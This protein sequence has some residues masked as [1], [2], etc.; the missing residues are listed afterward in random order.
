MMTV[1]G[2][3]PSGA[4]GRGDRS[5][6]PPRSQRALGRSWP[7][8]TGWPSRSSPSNP[9]AGGRPRPDSPTTSPRSW[10]ARCR[11][12]SAGRAR[13]T[14]TE[15]QSGHYTPAGSHQ[16]DVDNNA[17]AAATVVEVR[18]EDVVGQLH[19]ITRALV[20]CRSTSSRP[21]SRPSGLPVVDAFYVLGPDGGKLDRP[22]NHRRGRANASGKGSPL[23]RVDDPR[24]NLGITAW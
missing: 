24:P 13:P 2:S 20:D 19:R 16:V 5:T 12:T 9:G 15:L 11:L 6:G 14:P 8:R 3:R 17:S 4:A 7:A 1:V 22:R 10:R 18:A 23:S 21:R